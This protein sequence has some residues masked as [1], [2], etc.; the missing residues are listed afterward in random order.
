[1]ADEIEATAEARSGVS[2][3]LGK[4]HAEVLTGG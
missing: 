3:G 2:H 4:F 1:M